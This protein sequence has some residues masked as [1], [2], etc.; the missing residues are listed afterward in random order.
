VD[1]RNYQMKH[2]M[3]EFT[4]SVSHWVNG[5]THP[6]DVYVAGAEQP[7]GI[8]AVAHMLSID[9]REEDPAWMAMKLDSLVNTQSDDGFGYF[10]PATGS[11]VMAPSLVSGFAAVVKHR[12]GELGA[13]EATKSS[14]MLDALLSRKEPKTDAV[15]AMGWHVDVHNPA[16]GDNFLM[17]VK[18]LRLPDGTVRPYSVWLSGAYPRVLDGLT[19]LLSID[20]RISDP[21]WAI[22]KLS[23]LRTFGENRGDFLAQVPG[24]MRQ[25]NYPSTVAYIAE[26]LLHR[27]KVLGLVKQ[28]QGAAQAEVTSKEAPKTGGGMFCPSCNTMSL[29]KRDGC[30]VCDHCGFTGDCG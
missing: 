12:L 16:T 17:V 23:K 18:E 27:Y 21:A 14:L 2:P 9:M 6:L 4:V 13:L 10:D 8:A 30:K 11:E 26:L 24:E 20:M 28:E 19:K 22:R 25:Q 7:R 15:G 5:T 3:G 1:A 29:H